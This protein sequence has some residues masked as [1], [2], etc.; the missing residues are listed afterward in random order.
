[1]NIY[2][3]KPGEA[4]T[5]FPHQYAVLSAY[6]K[7]LGHNTNFYDAALTGESPESVLNRIDFKHIDAICMSVFTGWHRWASRFANLVKGKYPS[8]K[9]I[10][11]GPHISGLREY[12]VEH[13]GVDYGII[14]E[15]EI[16]LGKLLD[17]MNNLSKVK[18][19]PGVIYNDGNGYTLTPYP[20]ER[21]KDLNELPLPDYQLIPPKNYFH[22]Y[23][24]A[25]VAKKSVRIVQTVT[26]RGC[27]F[28]CTFCATNATWEKRI[29]FYSA[30]R[31]VEEIKYLISNF[32]IEEMWFGDDGF[33]ANR[34]RT[35][36]ICER[37]IKE[38]IRIPWRLPNGVRLETIDDSLVSLM[39]K[40]GCYMIGI[41]VET[42]S[43]DM[44]VRIKKKLD[45][46]I[47]NGKVRI[48]KRHKI[49]TSGFFIIG[50]PDETKEEL[51]NTIDFILK[52]PLERMQISIFAP[53]PGS[54]EFN[55][56]LE[57]DNKERY[58]ENVRKYLNNEYMPHFLKNLD[59]TTI[60]KYY[61]NTIL[62]F[63]LKPSVIESL[64]NNITL[65]QIRDI[66][67]HP[68]FRR[69][70]LSVRKEKET[71]VKLNN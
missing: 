66:T 61:R 9:I 12:A 60:Q 44:M 35:I 1:M 42:G 17:D 41:G 46:D 15:G 43:R 50:F 37:L 16:P 67:R 5:S 24:G 62:N 6:I 32:G 4:H 68:G 56:I 10:V 57:I 20:L 22:T 19:I 21:I 31:V 39:K 49:L 36:E 30:E 48:L 29:T 45:L 23:V 2:F 55:K 14:G 63:Y 58:S 27:P 3:I 52:S 18:K 28:G 47:V 69:I 33:T 7:K 40:A 59:I 70:F 53:Y 51:K 65:K 26:S 54:E 38:K 13:I 34:K 11:G 71:Y 64:I 8:I 25:S